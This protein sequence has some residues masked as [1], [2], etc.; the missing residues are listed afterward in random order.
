MPKLPDDW[1]PR[2]ERDARIE[3]LE[4]KIEAA[5]AEIKTSRAVGDHYLEGIV[6]RIEKALAGGREE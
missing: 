3:E 1:H 5:L 4:A 6:A 2:D